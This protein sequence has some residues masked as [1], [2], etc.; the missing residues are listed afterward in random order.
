MIKF[1]SFL[2]YLLSSSAIF[3]MDDGKG[4][5]GSF[6]RGFL[7]AKKVEAPKEGA[8]SS[9]SSS[10][11][12][13]ASTNTKAGKA[14]ADQADGFT[15]IWDNPLYNGPSARS[16]VYHHIKTHFKE[17]K[18]DYN[19]IDHFFSFIEKGSGLEEI[20]S[21]KTFLYSYL[22]LR[23]LSKHKMLGVMEGFERDAKITKGYLNI[24]ISFQIMDHL[25]VSAV[26]SLKDPILGSFLKSNSDKETGEIVV[27]Q[28]VWKSIERSLPIPTIR[29]YSE[30]IGDRY[31][32]RV[33]LTG[34]DYDDGIHDLPAENPQFSRY[35]LG[36]ISARVDSSHRQYSAAIL[37]KSGKLFDQDGTAIILGS[38]FKQG[39]NAFFYGTSRAVGQRTL[40]SLSKDCGYDSLHEQPYLQMLV[41]MAGGVEKLRREKLLFIP[42]PVFTDD[43]VHRPTSSPTAPDAQF[44]LPYI[45][46]LKSQMQLEGADVPPALEQAAAQLELVLLEDAYTRL[47]TFAEVEALRAIKAAANADAEK[48]VTEA[49]DA[50]D[51]A[52]QA[53]IEI[54]AEKIFPQY[55][56]SKPVK[57]KKS[58]EWGEKR[59]SAKAQ[60]I[61]EA[62]E[63][64][65]R[66]KV[67]AKDPRI[68]AK[69]K[70][71]ES[72]RTKYLEKTKD[73]RH[74]DSSAAKELLE[75][76]KASF[77]KIGIEQTGAAAVRGSHQA[78]EV[79]LIET[80]G[81][82]KLGVVRRS[83]SEGYASGTVRKIIDD[84]VN[85]ILSILGPSGK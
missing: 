5:L 18:I 64:R 82:V 6:P 16:Q 46:E 2:L 37:D 80:G 47:G 73:R 62:I 56:T 3:S 21:D 84:H 7:L 28:T 49:L 53:E 10:S 14:S 11:S 52:I 32:C 79:R 75:N 42:N 34:E 1:K 83:E 31:L 25:A 44:L 66:I 13:A 8:S 40:Q 54:K 63:E 38:I 51:G 30:N 29:Y 55:K 26:F 69:K 39:V 81:G 74:F 77:A 22:I 76:L 57:S 41:Q 9:S 24:P 50:K 12:V 48:E 61:R 59:G 85:R 60:A 45:Y 4:F 65:A 72:L 68:E 36:C 19:K 17:L 23:A 70:I 78:E 71:L 33:Y 67:A 15:S 20:L 27:D 35:Q 43:G 58:L